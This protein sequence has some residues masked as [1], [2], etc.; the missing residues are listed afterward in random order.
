MKQIKASIS[1][2][3]TLLAVKGNLSAEDCL[4]KDTRIIAYENDYS[5]GGGGWVDDA[6]VILGGGWSEGMTLSTIIYCTLSD[7]TFASIQIILADDKDNELE[8]RKHG[9]HGGE[10]REWDLEDDDY[11]R[12]F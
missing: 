10:C 5:L 8:L 7:N 4:L 11:I 12:I 2:V 9:I 1:L 6:E 3:T